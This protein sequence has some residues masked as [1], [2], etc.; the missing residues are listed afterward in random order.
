MLSQNTA[1]PLGDVCFEGIRSPE[2]AQDEITLRVSTG[3]RV[4][5]YYQPNALGCRN[6][7]IDEFNAAMRALAAKYFPRNTQ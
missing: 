5:T 6:A 1:P 3:E 4:A 2:D 7:L